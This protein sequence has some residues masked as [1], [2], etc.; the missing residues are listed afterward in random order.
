LLLL[1]LVVGGQVS[2]PAPPEVSSNSIDRC[3]ANV[4]A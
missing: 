4:A 2:I 1:F 3:I